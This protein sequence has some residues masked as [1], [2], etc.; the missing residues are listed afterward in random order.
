MYTYKDTDTGFN[1]GSGRWDFVTWLGTFG[2]SFFCFILNRRSALS[3]HLTDSDESNCSLP[4]YLSHMVVGQIVYYTTSLYLRLST[5]NKFTQY[6][7]T[8]LTLDLS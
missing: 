3:T 8:Y 1:I 5:R 4:S 6:N 7:N 2:C